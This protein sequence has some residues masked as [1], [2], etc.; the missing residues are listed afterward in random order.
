M[1]MSSS[2]PVVHTCSVN[3]VQQAIAPQMCVNSIVQ[4]THISSCNPRPGSPEAY[5]FGSTS[6]LSS[7]LMWIARSHMLENMVI[8][9]VCKLALQIIDAAASCEAS[10]SLLVIGDYLSIESLEFLTI[11][12]CLAEPLCKLARSVSC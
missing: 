9:W 10:A 7:I 4:Y 12:I 2:P 1:T 6:V 8:L 5:T 11:A 3:D